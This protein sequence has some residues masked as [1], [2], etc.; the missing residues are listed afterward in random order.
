MQ[1]QII[2][3]KYKCSRMCL[4]ST[5]DACPFIQLNYM[6]LNGRALFYIFSLNPLLVHL[7]EY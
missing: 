6:L 5:I 2:T 7:D 3:I 1:R 4:Q